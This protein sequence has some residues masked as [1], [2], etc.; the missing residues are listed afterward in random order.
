ME[1]R[2]VGSVCDS[3]EFFFEIVNIHHRIFAEPCA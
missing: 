2:I 3:H 1:S